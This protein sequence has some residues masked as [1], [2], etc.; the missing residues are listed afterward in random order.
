MGV[1]P[2]SQQSRALKSKV[3]TVSRCQSMLLSKVSWEFPPPPPPPPPPLPC[4]RLLFLSSH[5]P[6][7]EFARGIRNATEARVGSWVSWEGRGGVWRWGGGE[8]SRTRCTFG[9][10]HARL[11]K[12]P[13]LNSVGMDPTDRPTFSK[14][15]T[16]FLLP[17]LAK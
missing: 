1:G 5:S 15:C 4:M 3:E 13:L 9:G 7:S 14:I 10:V 11:H 12:W 6:S 17:S 2:P 16:H 8:N